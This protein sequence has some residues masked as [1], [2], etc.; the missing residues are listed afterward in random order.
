MKFIHA[1]L[2][3]A[4]GFSICLQA[5]AAD[6]GKAYVT[7][8]DGNVSVIDLATMETTGTVDIQANGTRGIGIT[9]D[10]RL[11]PERHI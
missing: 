9:D 6:A 10:G 7:N 3:T 11:G 5:S 8:Q 2:A 1:M 4:A